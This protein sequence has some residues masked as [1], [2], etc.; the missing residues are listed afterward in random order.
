MTSLPE[1]ERT[2]VFFSSGTT[3]QERSRHFHSQD[4]L[5]LYEASLKAAFGQTILHLFPLPMGEG[6]RVRGND[7]AVGKL[8]I[9][10]FT[11][12]PKFTLN[13][14]LVHMV[15]TLIKEFGDKESQFVG[16]LG[17]PNDWDL[18]FERAIE[19]LNNATKHN[20]PVLLLG[21]TFNF[22]HLVD[23]LEANNITFRLPAGSHALETGGYKGRSRELSKSELHNSISEKLGIPE[24]N[25][26]CEYGMS[27]LSSQAYD[28]AGANR[29]FQFPH[30][31]HAVI[32]SPETGREVAVGD[33]G[34]IRIFDLANVNSVMAIQ[35]EDL[36]VRHEIGFE[37]IGRAKLTEPRGCSLMT[38]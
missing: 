30:W 7:P 4:S 11:P 18:D 10:A 26:I 25:I 22:V 32:V 15:G 36:A 13:S 2:S 31:A 6:L 28:C 14:S 38:A 29:F 12:A 24:H 20:Q 33:T 35:T 17:S 5:E 19:A 1:S 34:L 27:E 16:R 37:L 3:Q 23:H 9:L 8:R 21:T